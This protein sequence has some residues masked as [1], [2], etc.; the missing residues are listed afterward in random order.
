M[1][2]PQTVLLRRM[3]V[4]HV[5][6]ACLV[7]LDPGKGGLHITLRSGLGHGLLALGRSK[8]EFGCRQ[9]RAGA[10]VPP[11]CRALVV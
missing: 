6:P 8:G 7:G 9:Q 4:S 5:A 11:C 10:V 3:Q 2:R 1:C